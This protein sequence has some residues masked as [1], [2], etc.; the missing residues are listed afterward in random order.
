M[1]I[2]I[3]RT[4]LELKINELVK[5]LLIKAWS[6]PSYLNRRLFGTIYN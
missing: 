3:S 5:Y 1:R 4:K 2:K 6:L